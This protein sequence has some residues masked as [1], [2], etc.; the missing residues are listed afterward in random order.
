MV[1]RVGL[2]PKADTRVLGSGLYFFL[3]KS[4]ILVHYLPSP[5]PHLKTHIQMYWWGR[6]VGT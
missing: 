5:S 4:H 6:G 2:I 3:V 1:E